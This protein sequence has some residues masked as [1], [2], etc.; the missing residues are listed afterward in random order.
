MLFICTVTNKL[1]QYHIKK[2]KDSWYFKNSLWCKPKFSSTTE[3]WLLLLKNNHSSLS[4]WWEYAKSCLNENA[5]TFSKN[6]TTQ[7][8]IRTSRLEKR[9]WN[10]HKKEN[11]K[12][13]I[14]PMI[15]N[16]QDE[17][18]QL[19]DK[20]AKDAKPC[21]NIRWELEGKKCSKTL[22]KA[23]EWQ[24]MQD[25]TISKLYTDDNT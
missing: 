7:E 2:R 14:K 4:D 21:I 19:E 13:K 10:L 11:F 23:I 24:N 8:N 25:Q 15:E 9:L 5:R 18:Y 1:R 12:P 6:S 20:Q 3:N 16:F 22:S 17:L